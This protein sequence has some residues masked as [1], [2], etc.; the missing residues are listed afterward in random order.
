MNK[1]HEVSNATVAEGILSLVVDGIRVRQE[2]RTVSPLF[3]AATNEELSRFEISPSGYGIHWPL[4]DGDL[5][6]DGLLGILHEP[7]TIKKSA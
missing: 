4:I 3:R 2:L 6:L 7:E 1:Y 5:S